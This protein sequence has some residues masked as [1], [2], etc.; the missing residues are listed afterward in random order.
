MEPILVDAFIAIGYDLSWNC[1]LHFDDH[2]FGQFD[3]DHDGVW[4][5]EELFLAQQIASNGEARYVP[6]CVT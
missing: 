6:Y 4:N 5:S 3:Q 2:V 1:Q